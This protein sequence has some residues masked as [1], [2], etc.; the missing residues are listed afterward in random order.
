[1]NTNEQ[2]QLI[3]LELTRADLNY[4]R[5]FLYEESLA[6]EIDHENVEA[7]HNDMAIRAAKETLSREHA[8]MTKI[9]AVIDKTLSLVN[10]HDELRDRANEILGTPAA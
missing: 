7:L 10:K 9:V 3:P 4:L 1:M 5:N 6:A 2:K 8:R